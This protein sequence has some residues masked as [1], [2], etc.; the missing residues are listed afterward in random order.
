MLMLSRQ[1]RSVAEVP[2]THP[3]V[4]RSFRCSFNYCNVPDNLYSGDC[5]GA[6]DAIV[7]EYAALAAQVYVECSS[8]CLVQTG[9]FRILT[10]STLY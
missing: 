6:L 5:A 4:L 3:D 10:M 1:V 8:I 7:E 9:C 2:S